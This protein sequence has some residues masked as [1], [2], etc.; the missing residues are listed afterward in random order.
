MEPATN[1]IHYLD[2]L[3]ISHCSYLFVKCAFPRA[4]RATSLY[5]REKFSLPNK[6]TELLIE[7]YNFV[8]AFFI[9]F[10]PI[11]TDL[12]GNTV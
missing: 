3:Q 2:N 7:Q 1:L 6:I 4:K 12:S 11:K 10:C 9:N 5:L 8:M